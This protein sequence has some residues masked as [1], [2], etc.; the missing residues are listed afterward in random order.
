MEIFSALLALCEGIHQSPVDSPQKASHA[1][2]WRFAR[3][4]PEQ[5]LEQAIGTP[6]IWEAIA[7]IVT[8]L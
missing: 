3:S 1:E 6:V 5:T 8:P 4:V 2:R 7:L